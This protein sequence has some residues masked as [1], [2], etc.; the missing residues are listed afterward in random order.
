MDKKIAGLLGAA[1]ALTTM[2]AANAGASSQS[3]ELAPAT[4][5]RD[6][7]DPVPNPIASLRADDARLAEAPTAEGTAEGTQVAQN[8]H[9]HHHH[10]HHHV[11]P[12]PLRRVL[13]HRHHHHHHHHHHH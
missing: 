12:R 10:H 2:T 3:S 4:S 13:P 8:Y 6:L 7:L 11:I 1:A 5:Y 9:H